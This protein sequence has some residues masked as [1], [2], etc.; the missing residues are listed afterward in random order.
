MAVAM[1]RKVLSGGSARGR[2]PLS[3]N[4]IVAIASR[5]LA[6]PPVRAGSFPRVRSVLWRN[7]SSG[8]RLGDAVSVDHIVAKMAQHRNMIELVAALLFDKL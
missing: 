4:R 6:L 7:R 3:F 2:D 8:P 5:E 1:H